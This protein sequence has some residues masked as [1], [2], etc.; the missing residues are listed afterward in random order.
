MSV[1]K[2]MDH[3]EYQHKTRTMRE[4][5]LYYTMRDCKQAMLAN[6]RGINDGYYADEINYCGMEL[7]R[8]RR[9]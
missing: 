3:A 6:P 5:E 7:H 8:R 4:E 2:V 9:G 1:K